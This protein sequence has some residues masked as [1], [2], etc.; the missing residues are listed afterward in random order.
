MTNKGIYMKKLSSFTRSDRIISLISVL[1]LII[2]FSAKVGDYDF[3]S[4]FGFV[5]FLPVVLVV[6]IK[7]IMSA[8]DVNKQ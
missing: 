8:K 6:G 5:G 2:V 3:L 1:W 7:W 4:A